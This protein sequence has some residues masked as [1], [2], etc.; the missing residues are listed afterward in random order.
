[1]NLKAL[2]FVLIL[3]VGISISSVG[4]DKK[5]VEKDEVIRVDT[6]LVDVPLAVVDGKGAPIRGL[7]AANFVIYEN[8]KKQEVV[9]FSTTSEPFEVALLLDTSGSTRGDLVLIQRAAQE[10]ITSLRPGDRVAILSY[11][12]D[13]QGTQAFATTEILSR[14]TDDRT[15]LKSA[16]EKVK[17]SNG[18]PLY[19]S[20]LQVAEKVFS[21]RP[22]E[23]FRGRRALVAL[24]DGVDSTSS[25]DFSL[26]RQELEQIGLISYFIKVDTRDFF[27][28]NLLGD[29]QSAIRFST[30]QI[31]RY[32]KSFGPKG[33]EN[34]NLNFC[35]LGDFERLAISKKLYEI[36]DDEMEDLAKTSGGKVF[37]VDDLN[38]A[39]NAFRSVAE[40]I[41]TKYT[42]GY[43]SSNE[44]RDGTYRKIKIEMKGLPT[45]T[46]IRTRDGYTAPGN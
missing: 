22:A 36:A 13:R 7:K 9:D 21:Q 11:N 41:G 6:Q 43:Y 24:T 3:T 14:L 30:A 4:Q 27:E 38:Q 33:K 17:T 44:K 31:K 45:G 39:R 19:D 1:M 16:I 25:A 28:Q 35:S 15:V 18:T 23:E 34:T 12:T 26:A 10:F 40:E 2:I 46:Q 8:G 20:L 42:I 29:C 5:T 37:P 32:F